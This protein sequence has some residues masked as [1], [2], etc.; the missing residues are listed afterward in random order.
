VPRSLLQPASSTDPAVIATAEAMLAMPWRA[1]GRPVDLW[2]A[3]TGTTH[4]I[5]LAALAHLI[6]AGLC[7]ERGGI[8]RP[9]TYTVQ[10]RKAPR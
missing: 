7:H 8:T 6:A 1:R 3:D 9:L 10:P 2:A 5:A 4:D